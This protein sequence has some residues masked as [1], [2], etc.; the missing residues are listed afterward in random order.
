MFA[1]PAARR[2]LMAKLRRV[3]VR[4]GV[5][6][7]GVLGEGGVADEVETALDD[8]LQGT[9]VG[10]SAAQITDDVDSLAAALAAR[11]L[12]AVPDDLRDLDRVGE[13][14]PEFADRQGLHDA[15]LQTAVRAGVVVELS[16]SPST[17]AGRRVGG[18]GSSDCA[19]R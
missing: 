3:V 6:P 4:A 7:A 8:P 18:A 5:D 16:P 19:S 10:L 14:H 12:G 2:V 1:W 17:R 9:I 15:S 11:A 13:V